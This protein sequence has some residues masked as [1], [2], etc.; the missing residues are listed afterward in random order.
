M[1]VMPAFGAVMSMLFLGETL[2]LFHLAGAALI[3]VGIL[4]STR[5]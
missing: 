3:G 5:P 1:N 2:H 4:L